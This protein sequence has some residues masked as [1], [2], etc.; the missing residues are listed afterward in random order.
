VKSYLYALTTIIPGNEVPNA[1]NDMAV[2]LSFRPQLQPKCDAKSP[3]NAVSTPMSVI[4]TI[5]HAQPPHMSVS[6]QTNMI[7]HKR[8]TFFVRRFSYQWV[9][10]MQTKS[11]R[12]MKYNA[13]RS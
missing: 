3:I 6:R 1:T 12:T 2:T 9:E 13:K 8:K 7:E 4:D 10:Q 5:K 11:S